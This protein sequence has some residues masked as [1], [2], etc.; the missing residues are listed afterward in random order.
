MQR[1]SV[2][3]VVTD[4]EHSFSFVLEI[5]ALTHECPHPPLLTLT[6]ECCPSLPLIK[7]SVKNQPFSCRSQLESPSKTIFLNDFTGK[8]NGLTHLYDERNDY[9]IPIDIWMEEICGSITQ[10]SRDLGL[11]LHEYD[12]AMVPNLGVVKILLDTHMII[13]VYFFGL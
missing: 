12:L 7:R 13:N 11:L 9:I 4:V 3:K 6:Y 1:L 2:K 10:P 5:L 8:V